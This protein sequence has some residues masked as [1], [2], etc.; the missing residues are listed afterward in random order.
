MKAGD[1]GVDTQSPEGEGT[2]PEG[3]PAPEGTEGHHSE[4]G[5]GSPDA[6]TPP[7]GSEAGAEGGEGDKSQERINGLM[8]KW[9][10]E[11]NAHNETKGKLAQ[12]EKQFGP[13]EGQ[14]KPFINN[15]K[16]ND[17]RI[18]PNDPNLPLVLRDG[19]A[20]KDMAD[21]QE[22]IKQAALYGASIGSKQALGTIDSQ[23][24]TKVDAEKAVDD[25][26]AEVKTVDTEFDDKA[27]FKYASDHKFPLNNV[28]DLR[29]VYSS[30]ITLRRA[31]KDAA[32][33]AIK[34]KEGRQNPSGKPGSGTGDAGTKMP[35]TK[36]SKAGS[37]Q[38]IIHD[39]F[40][41]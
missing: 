13:L 1:L 33:D 5:A 2:P 7:E 41:K 10:T 9:Q 37:A 25:F 19:W 3:S 28:G 24:Q 34:N 39:H 12:Y 15:Q 26:V 36:I 23:N 4:E 30:Y 14:S 6:G 11:E 29:A 21:L 8:S 35:F 40:K 38:D 22:G 32:T 20:P 16:S 17:S 18:D 31:T 27:F